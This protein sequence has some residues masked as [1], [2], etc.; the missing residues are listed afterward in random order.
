[1]AVTT[2]KGDWGKTHVFATN[3]GRLRRLA[4][5]AVQIEAIG[6]VDEVN[7]FLGIVD[8][9][10]SDTKLSQKL[11]QIQEDLFWAGAYLA[12]KRENTE[13]LIKRIAGIEKKIDEIEKSLP[14]QK[15]FVLP[16]GARV[17][18]LLFYARAITRRAERRIV[19]LGRK[20]KI[21]RQIGVYFNRLSDYLFLLARR[22]NKNKR[23]VEIF[24][25]A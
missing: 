7:S 20:G 16:G 19:S 21:D 9:F 4:K 15:N 25:K 14:V 23:V 22:E 12:G 17:A 10:S 2:K 18:A 11:H 6:A 13:F 3:T 1:M 24:W 5:D 8:S